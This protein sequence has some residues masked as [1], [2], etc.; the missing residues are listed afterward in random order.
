[1]AKE[2]RQVAFSLQEGEV[3]DPFETE[4][5]YHI[6]KI[7]EPPSNKFY[8]VATIVKEIAPSDETIEVAF[9]KAGL[10]QA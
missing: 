3:S 10:F 1:M 7:T 5:G 9:R 6:I 2:F 4:F 8:K